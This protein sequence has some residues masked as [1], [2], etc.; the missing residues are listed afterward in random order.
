MIINPKIKV[1]IEKIQSL[2]LETSHLNNFI[3]KNPNTAAASI[4]TNVGINSIL[5]PD[6]IASLNSNI[7]AAIIAGIPN[8]KEKSIA[9]F[10]SIFCI[11]PTDKVEPERESPGNTAANI[12]AKPIKNEFFE[13]IS[14][15][16]FFVLFEDFEHKKP[17]KIKILVKINEIPIGKRLPDS[18]KLEANDFKFLIFG[19]GTNKK[20]S[21]KSAIIKLIDNF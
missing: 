10:L 14:K 21:G 20:N 17:I 19:S 9:D 1:Y 12:W 2:L 5:M 13:L 3:D 6:S 18:A 7:D 16:F 15:I 8:R 11:K 4:P